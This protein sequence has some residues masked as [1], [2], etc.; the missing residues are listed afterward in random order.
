MYGAYANRT[1]GA[2]A[3]RR[4]AAASRSSLRPPAA[5]LAGPSQGISRIS[6]E[7]MARFNIE[8]SAA[9][10]A[11]IDPWRVDQG[12]SLDTQLVNRAVCYLQSPGPFHFE[13][14]AG[15]AARTTTGAARGRSPHL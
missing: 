6:D 1:R 7:E 10:A 11:W 2:R 8:A 12:G 9:L 4:A 13:F 3:R 14:E 5:R 15:A